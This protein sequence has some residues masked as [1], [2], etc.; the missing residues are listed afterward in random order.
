[1]PDD[2]YIEV[3]D[4]ISVGDNQVVFVTSDLYLTSLDQG[5]P[6]G[7]LQSIWDL[8]AALLPGIEPQDDITPEPAGF[9]PGLDGYPNLL[10]TIGR[11]IDQNFV[12]TGRHQY[13][14]SN[15]PPS[16]DD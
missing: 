4:V 3:T 8:A 14:I 11:E 15:D 7:W 5:D 12:I 9:D 2:Q 10:V 13:F 6:V 1:M 16:I